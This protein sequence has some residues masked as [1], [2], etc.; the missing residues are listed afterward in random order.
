MSTP[1]QKYNHRVS[2]YLD[3]QDQPNA[4][5]VQRMTRC[6]CDGGPALTEVI[7]GEDIIVGA[8]QVVVR[9][10]R[11]CLRCGKGC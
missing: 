5:R 9:R 11:V 4:E 3:T 7:V 8:K 2:G 1:K 6:Q 10:E